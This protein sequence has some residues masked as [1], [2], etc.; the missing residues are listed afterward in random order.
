MEAARV[1]ALRGHEVDLYEKTDRLGGVFNEASAFDFK[2]DD[3]RLLAWY[4]KQIKDTGVNVKFNTEFKVEDK[5]KYDVVFVATGASEK[6]LD[7]IPGFDQPNVRYA[8]DVLDKQDIKDQNVVIIGGGLTGCE[9]AYDLA[10]KNKKVSV[11]EALPTIMNVEGL[12]AP[13]YNM[14]VE[15][16]EHYHVDIYK[17]ATV[18]EYKDGKLLINVMTTNQPN[19]NN[20][21]RMMSWF[22]VHHI[23]KT[24]D[25]DTVVVSV[26]YKSNQTL[27]DSIKGDNVYLLGDAIHP[28]NLMTAIWGAYTIALKV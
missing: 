28:S 23:P 10:R 8:V 22:G 13:N 18:K 26:G 2:D 6:R 3:R 5:E 7:M 19:I 12:A 1:A 15:L 4:K 17:N 24:L 14:L 25:A 20:R 27:Y 16:M 11:V 21:A 9:L